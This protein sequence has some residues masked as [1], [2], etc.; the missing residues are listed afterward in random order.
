MLQDLPP[1]RGETTE[2]RQQIASKLGLPYHDAMQ[3]WPW[4][5]ASLD[6]LQDYLQLYA[7]SSE[8]ERVVLMAMMLQATT[9]VEEPVAFEHAWH[10]VEEL[11]DQNPVLH[12]WSA[13]YWCCW[14]ASAEGFFEVTPFIR[15]WWAAHFTLP[16]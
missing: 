10:H 7:S 5:A 16:A 13:Y 9:E 4:E 15:S 2:A 1:Q 14:G 6:H 11:L 8:D 12:A 3:D